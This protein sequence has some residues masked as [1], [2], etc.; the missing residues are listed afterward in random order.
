MAI[1]DE[2]KR[3]I[4]ISKQLLD[5]KFVRS[6][7]MS[8][9]VTDRDEKIKKDIAAILEITGILKKQ[10]VNDNDEDKL[11]RLRTFL[12]ETTKLITAVRGIEFPM[13]ME[14]EMEIEKLP[15]KNQETQIDLNQPKAIMD[16]G[17]TESQTNNTLNI[18]AIADYKKATQEFLNTPSDLIGALKFAINNFC[19]DL[20][21]STKYALD[22]LGLFSLNKQTGTNTSLTHLKSQAVQLSNTLSKIDYSKNVDEQKEG[23]SEAPKPHSNKQ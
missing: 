15:S 7:S 11:K 17:L 14:M 2:N 13:L 6:D 21:F 18:Q 20:V 1:N 9:S 19:H 4:E 22:A 23:D 10:Y 3:I 8:S 12:L 5:I 16:Q